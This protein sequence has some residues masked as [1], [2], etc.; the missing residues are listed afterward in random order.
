M[1]NLSIG[2]CFFVAAAIWAP[3]DS[4]RWLVNLTTPTAPF[5]EV[6]PWP[7]LDPLGSG[8]MEHPQQEIQLT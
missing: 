6:M 4:A 3:G 8:G 5:R 2:V 1:K 7:G